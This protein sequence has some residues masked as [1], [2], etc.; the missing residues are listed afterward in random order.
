MAESARQ[1][2]TAATT[3]AAPGLLDQIIT[4]TKQTEPDRA[5]DLVKTLVEQALA[6]TVTFDRNLTRTFDKAVAAIDAKM[7]AQLNA[8]M[9]DPKFL[10]LE[11]SWR[12]LHYLVQNSETGTSLKLRVLN[13]SKRELGRDLSRAIEF[14]QSQM[15]KKIYEN[16]FGT[17][18][19]EP[20]GALI[21]DYEWTNHPDDLETLRLMSNIAAGAFAPFIS[22]A[23]AGMFGFD[24]WTELSKPR[25]L[26][27]I[28]DTVEFQKW[29]SFGDSADSRF[30]NLVMPRVI[31]RLPYGAATKPIDEFAYEEAPLDEA[32]AALPMK[33]G[34]YCWVNVA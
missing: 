20:Y 1:S 10:K 34:E 11:G 5:Q 4:N 13:L 27:K 26:A 7:S 17:P 19:G 33:H 22:A 15:F 6:G 3:E 31:S 18:G 32:G 8:I 30:V 21:G 28:F 9:H 12:G 2:G 14:D 23:A 25:D 16:E 29:R 24:S